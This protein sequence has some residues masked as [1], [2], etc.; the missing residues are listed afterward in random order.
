MSEN[1]ILVG[2]GSIGLSHL[3]V[4][5]ERNYGTI[6]VIDIDSEKE[7]FL[8]EIQPNAKFIS[9]LDS[10][11]SVEPSTIVVIANWGPDHFQLITEIKKKG[12]R[13][14]I[15]EKP[16]VS[17]LADLQ[18]LDNFSKLNQIKLICNFSIGF[19]PLQSQ[20]TEVIKD[21][22]LGKLC[23]ISVHGGAKCLATNGIHYLALANN[24]FDSNPISVSSNAENSGI[25]PRGEELVFLGG[26]AN[27]TYSESRNLTIL[28]SNSSHNQLQINLEFEFGR[29]MIEGD[30]ATP[31]SI[32]LEDR[33]KLDKPSRTLYPKL[34]HNRGFSI[35]RGDEFAGIRRL[36]EYFLTETVVNL[37]YL[38]IV[39][40]EGIISALISSLEKRVIELPISESLQNLYKEFDWKIS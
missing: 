33:K 13:N 37:K 35:S 15:V 30:Q 25:N 2:L 11:E 39:E 18:S 28:F 14:F 9:D 5:S 16:L 10:L 7:K 26:Y 22:Q 34:T 27:W 20:L 23:N 29:V 17:K 1:Y 32:P 21:L 6:T 40:C 31:Y 8:H 36:Y 3:K 12:A 38:G 19:S 24:L 4:I